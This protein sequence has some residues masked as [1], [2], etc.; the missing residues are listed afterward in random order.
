MLR[1]DLDVQGLEP[2]PRLTDTARRVAQ[3]PR[4]GPGCSGQRGEDANLCASR[5]DHYR[6]ALSQQ[7][8]LLVQNGCHNRVV[9]AD[10][11]ASCF[12]RPLSRGSGVAVFAKNIKHSG[13]REEVIDEE[14]KAIH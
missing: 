10:D 8:R 12:G 3:P 11:L 2:L 9:R 7:P 13:Y 14:L 1:P 6:E 5:H 4:I